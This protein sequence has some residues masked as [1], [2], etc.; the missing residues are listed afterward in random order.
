MPKR[1]KVVTAPTPGR[2]PSLQ[3]Q[4]RPVDTF[5]QSLAMP[6]AQGND[7]LDLAQALSSF[8]PS[9]SRYADMKVEEYIQEGE[10]ASLLQGSREANRAGL[11]AAVDAGQ[12]PAGANPWFQKG[13]KRQQQRVAAEEY[14]TA[15]QAAYIQSSARTSKDPGEYSAFIENFTQEYVQSRGLESDPEFANV[16]MPMAQ[17][18]Q[19][20]L[21]SHHGAEVVGQIEQEVK[22][23]TY[24]E[25]QNLIDNPL[26]GPG[27][28]TGDAIQATLADHVKN[29]LMGAEANK[30]AI[31]SITDHAV[32]NGDMDILEHLDSINTGNGV[33]GKTKYAQEQRAVAETKILNQ[34]QANF[35][36]GKAISEYQKSV[37]ADRLHT[38][39]IEQ[40]EKDP[41]ADIGP[42]VIQMAKVDPKQAD[43]L[44][45]YQNSALSRKVKVYEDP[46]TLASIYEELYS[47]AL[48]PAKITSHAASGE[49]DP[50]TVGTLNKELA[51]Y[52][53]HRGVLGSKSFSLIRGGMLKLINGDEF[54]F[55]P[56]R[57][58]HAIDADFELQRSFL[59]W[60]ASEEG[61]KADD[62]KE[63]EWLQK[64]A[65]QLNE[66]WGADDP[67]SSKAGLQSAI[68]DYNTNGGQGR[69]AEDAA[70]AKLSVPDFIRLKK[71]TA[72]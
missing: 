30:I 41:S 65:K 56:E 62:L 7:A 14:N 6:P 21:A 43:D 52:N 37:M 24:K 19:S 66:I 71:Q 18:A 12:M 72:K 27:N 40:I 53:Q 58:A 8:H 47:G 38:Q 36:H 26:A 1:G 39:A 4:A 48:T 57:N 9:L 10:K 46:H 33:L 20:N 15:L 61:E 67:Y 17:A 28:P 34:Q 70:K 45:A 11:K 29:G 25:I 2:Q 44:R 23:N 68:E 59:K 69:L 3:P 35:S 13:W 5:H 50:G 55:D 16:F 54:N 31:D 60:K 42:L 22:D 64:R 32:A 49:I 63:T 51:I